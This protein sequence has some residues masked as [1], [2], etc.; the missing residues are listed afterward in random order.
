MD[1]YPIEREVKA[2]SIT[3]AVTLSSG[4]GDGNIKFTLIKFK[5]AEK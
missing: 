2:P 3:L 1:S 5:V 4:V